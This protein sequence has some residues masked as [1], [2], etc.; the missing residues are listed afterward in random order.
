MGKLKTTEMFVAELKE[1]FKDKPYTFEKVNYSGSH[2]YVTVTCKIHGDF[3]AMATNLQQGK[4]CRSCGIESTARAKRKD[5]DYFIKLSREVHGDRYDYSLVDYNGNNTKVKILCK[6]H[7][8]FEQVPLSHYAGSGCVNCVKRDVK[9]FE[10]VLNYIPKDR[11]NI[12]S[13]ISKHNHENV[14]LADKVTVKCLIHNN[15]F[16]STFHYLTNRKTCCEITRYEV[17]SDTQRTSEEEYLRI[18]KDIHG[19]K[20]EYSSFGLVNKKTKIEIKCREHGY[21][22]QTIAKHIERK[23]G[24]PE[25][26][27]IKSGLSKSN[28]WLLKLNDL[29]L[30]EIKGEGY[31]LVTTEFVKNSK[32]KIILNCNE[33]GNFG[34]SIGNL[35]QGQRCPECNKYEGWGKSTYIKHSKLN[36]NGLSNLYLIKCSNKIESFYKVGITV[37]NDIRRRFPTKSMPYNYELLSVINSDVEDIIDLEVSIHKAVKEYHYLPNISFGGHVKECFT[38]SGLDIAKQ[39]IQDYKLNYKGD[40]IEN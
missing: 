21:F 29:V 13:I 27:Q 24:C 5:T 3:S 22:Y 26:G 16:T 11:L 2:K 30:D 17:A 4:G 36:Y 25:C 12:W 19:D 38:E 33:H 20:Y 8:I 39:M 18:F 9:T 14:K 7:G 6:H 32:D 28:N 1:L 37:H 15:I 40:S 10:D 31:S 23:Q 35:L 34:K